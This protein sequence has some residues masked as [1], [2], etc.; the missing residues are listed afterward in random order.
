MEMISSSDKIS[1]FSTGAGSR[2]GFMLYRDYF[3]DAANGWQQA[4]SDIFRCD[5]VVPGRGKGEL[6][7]SPL[8]PADDVAVTLIVRVRYLWHRRVCRY[9]FDSPTGSVGSYRGL[10]K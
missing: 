6:F 9:E 1:C 5:P 8:V 10:H 3:P 2:A 4:D 7:G